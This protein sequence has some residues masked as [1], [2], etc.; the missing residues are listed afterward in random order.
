DKPTQSFFKNDNL[1]A[2]C[3][4]PYL[5]A[6]VAATCFA[7][8][9]LGG[10][11]SFTPSTAGFTPAQLAQFN[12]QYPGGV[13]PG[14]L[15]YGQPASVGNAYTYNLQTVLQQTV[16]GTNNWAMFPAGRIVYGEQNLQLKSVENYNDRQLGRLVLGTDGVFT[17]FGVD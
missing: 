6:T 15:A 11:G 14:N 2:G 3:D 12:A 10:G 8:N 17:A 16:P 13:I 4:N 5:P 1:E 9:G 7:Y